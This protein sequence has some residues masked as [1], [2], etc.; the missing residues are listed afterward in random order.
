MRVMAEETV[1][2]SPEETRRMGRELGRSLRGGELILLTGSIGAGK[3]VFARGVADALG[4]EEWRGSPSFALV[5]EYPTRPR[6]IHA[7]LYRLT[8]PEAADL[9]LEQYSSDDS[10]LLVE[11]ADRAA[12][13]LRAS[14]AADLVRVNLQILG[15]TERLLEISLSDSRGS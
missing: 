9:G 13:Y 5:H 11:W 15:P 4:A 8:A 6:L 3:S 2:R 1:T 7:D 12:E 14:M 10:V